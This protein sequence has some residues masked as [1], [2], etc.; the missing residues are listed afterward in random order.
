MLSF[1]GFNRTSKHYDGS[2]EI[3]RIN[4]YSPEIALYKR[5]GCFLQFEIIMNGLV[6]L[7][8]PA[9]FEYICCVSTAII[10]V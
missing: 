2:Y 10:N 5:K 1:Q 8:L 4:S 9:S 3:Q 6:K 7:A